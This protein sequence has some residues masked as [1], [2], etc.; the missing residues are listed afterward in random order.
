M[1][2]GES[3]ANKRALQVSFAERGRA[4]VVSLTER[5]ETGLR[6]STA[7]DLYCL[8]AVKTRVIH[9]EASPSGEVSAIERTDEVISAG[10]AHLRALM[11]C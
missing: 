8:K 4:T 11:G 3:V 1:Q 6:R 9:S 5:S 2:A 7:T 10:G